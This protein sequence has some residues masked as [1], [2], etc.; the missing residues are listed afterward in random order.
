MIQQARHGARFA[1]IKVN[2]ILDKLGPHLDNTK[3]PCATEADL[4]AGDPT[5]AGMSRTA[6]VLRG[7]PLTIA[8]LPETAGIT[9]VCTSFVGESF[10]EQVTILIHE[11]HHGTP[12]IP[13][14]DL[15]YSH[16][17]LITAV[18]TSSALENAASFHLY[19]QPREETGLRGGRA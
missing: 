2:R 13:S 14:S 15:A 18:S 4:A 5:F 7:V 8:I 16:P 17:R 19:I 1:S 9:H 11:G 12:G 3:R 10:D 6:A